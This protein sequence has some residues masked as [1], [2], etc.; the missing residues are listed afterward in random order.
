MMF[1][2]DTTAHLGKHICKGTRIRFS[3]AQL[4][5]VLA[6]IIRTHRKNVAVNRNRPLSFRGIRLASKDEQ[7]RKAH[8]G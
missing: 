5:A 7:R 6:T 4:R 8:R 3:I 2:F 1:C